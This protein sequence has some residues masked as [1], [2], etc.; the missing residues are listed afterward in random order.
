MGTAQATHQ[1]FEDRLNRINKGAAN[2]M[3][4]VHIGPRDEETARAGK[5]TNTVRMK[6]RKKKVKVGEG[7]NL[8]LVPVA[9]VIGGLSVF[10]GQ[11]A[12]FHFFQDGGLMPVTL[13]EAIG[14]V[15]PYLIHAHLVIG[16]LLAL[17][18]TWTFGFNGTLRK[19]AVVAGFGAMLFGQAQMMEQFPGI[20]ANFFS[21][22][23]V[24]QTLDKT[25]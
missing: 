20:Y 10:A 18:F 22:A 23:Y 11:A 16:G 13:P 4:E 6:S 7:S 19:L 25:V 17:I 2:T 12:A 14:M 15:E 9:I 3:G 21:E 24:A 1:T 5:T 8:V